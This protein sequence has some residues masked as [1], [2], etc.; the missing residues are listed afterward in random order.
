MAGRD[1]DHYDDRPIVNP[2]SPRQAIA[3]ERVP[4]PPSKRARHPIIIVGNAIFTILLLLS[5]AVGGGIIYGSQKF[6]AP[7]PLDRER[8]VNIPPRTGLRDMADL[9]KREGV[10]ENPTF[11]VLGA[12][13]L[14][15]TDKLKAG[16]YVFEKG[17]SMDDVLETII[18]GKSIQHSVTIAEGLTTQQ[19]IQRLNEADVL[20]GPVMKVPPEGSLLP[21][22]YRVTR[23]TSRDQLIQRMTESNRRL[24]NEIWAR[25]SPDLPVKDINEFITL[26]S[27]VEKETAIASERTRVAG[28]FVNRLNKKMR[29]QSDP[30]I[31][32]GLVGGK[33]S[34]GRSLTRADVDQ[35]TP[36]NTYTINGLPPGPIANPGR[37][38]LEAVA[39]PSRT[40]ELY[41]VADGTGG[42]VFAETYEQHLKNVARWRDFQK[43]QKDK[44]P[45]DAVPPP[46]PVQQVQPQT[47]T[48]TTPTFGPD[49]KTKEERAAEQRKKEEKAAEQKRK[50]EKAADAKKKKAEKKA[51]VEKK[52]AEAKGEKKDE[53]K[54][55][56]KQ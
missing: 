40:K 51:E 1:D 45:L 26:A 43:E 54:D 6:G 2:R 9:L 29:L 19:I 25:R 36:Y 37:A 49:T 34:L 3:P 55:E 18:S 4:P 30:T 27:I 22:T 35:S 14:G 47:Q 21:E 48:L 20:S 39:N 53:K 42:H 31:I 5:V 41:F 33:G 46:A 11:F 52:K 24:V 13:I 17:A 10:I 32:Y 8:T 7:G 23:G 12:V 50:Q 38:S 15:A 44:A 28:V 16:E 56:P